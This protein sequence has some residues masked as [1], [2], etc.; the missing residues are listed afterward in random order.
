MGAGRGSMAG[1]M[2]MAGSR[3]LLIS[4][5]GGKSRELLRSG[6]AVGFTGFHID[7]QLDWRVD[8]RRPQILFSLS[9][10]LVRLLEAGM[11][12]RISR[13]LN[14]FAG[15]VGDSCPVSSFVG[16][17]AG[18]VASFSGEMATSAHA[19]NSSCGPQPGAVELF[20]QVPQLFPRG[21]IYTKT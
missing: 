7:F 19:R 17:T 21:R 13:G 15:F 6:R 12:S 18:V 20:E 8:L 4:G 5:R 1:G 11:L 16:E 9:A 10:G 2:D 3:E 14:A